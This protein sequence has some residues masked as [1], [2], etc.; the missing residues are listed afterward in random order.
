MIRTRYQ[1]AS[2]TTSNAIIL[3]KRTN[4]IA[5]RN[6]PL[7]IALDVLYMVQIAASADRQERAA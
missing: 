7:S 4:D 2:C 6:C 3:D 1:F 5:A